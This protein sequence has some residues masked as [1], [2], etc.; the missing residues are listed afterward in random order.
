MTVIAVKDGI[1]AA[2][3]GL[4]KGAAI[5]GHQRKIIRLTDGRLFAASGESGAV[6]E[7]LRW[8]NGEADRPTPETQDD[9]GAL[10][11]APD[12]V[13]RIDYKYRLFRDHA[14]FPCCGAHSEMLI[15]A[16]AAGASA[17]EAVCIAIRYGDSAAGDVQVE[18]LTLVALVAA[19]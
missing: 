13:W 2:D 9:F 8:L 16:M 6:Q 12:G 1:M 3:T 15:G 7:C 5:Y 11:L 10:I 18:R 14:N 17:E 19:E 4:W